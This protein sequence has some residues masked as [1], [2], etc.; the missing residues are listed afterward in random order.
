M[1]RRIIVI[2]LLILISGLTGSYFVYR[3]YKQK[4]FR[5]HITSNIKGIVCWGDSLTYGAGGDGTTYPDTLKKLISKNVGEIPVYNLGVGGES[6]KQIMAR[7]GVLEIKL[8]KNVTIPADS[9]PVKVKLVLSDGTLANFLRQGNAGMEEV[10]IRNIPGY[11]SIKQKN[12]SEG[13]YTYYFTREKAGKKTKVLAGESVQVDSSIK[14]RSC[15]PIIFMG[16][17]GD[18]T[19]P[20]DL[21]SQIE[22]FIDNQYSMGTERYLVL[23][24]TAGT[25]EERSELEKAMKAHFGK[26]YINLR[27]YLS[28]KALDDAG[29]EA[30][31]NDKKQIA[32]GMVP[33]SLRFDEVHLNAT[34]YKLV[35]KYVYKH[36]QELGYF[37]YKIN[38][39]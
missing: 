4:D 32:L 12:I 5:Q 9:T 39:K 33:E 19:S 17:N 8:Q 14:Y 34:G 16:T 15:I 10:R 35:G 24:L 25:R 2:I 36:M 37:D 13:K 22:S 1:R 30:T 7:A 26:R 20:K 23:G 28:T 38:V 3:N 27:E 29:I 18:W 11:L 6:T 21:I 31:D